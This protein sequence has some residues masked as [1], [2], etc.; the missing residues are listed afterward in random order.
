MGKR[1]DAQHRKRHAWVDPHIHIMP[2]RR[3]AG[4]VRWVKK[5]TPDSPSAKT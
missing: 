2:P 5:F 3:M 1:Q 4:L